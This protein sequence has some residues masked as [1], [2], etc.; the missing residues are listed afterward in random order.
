MAATPLHKAMEYETNLDGGALFWAPLVIFLCDVYLGNIQTLE[1][2]GDSTKYL[3]MVM[4][5]V[6]NNHHEK[7]Q[8]RFDPQI[9]QKP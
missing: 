2:I 8:F 3:P 9:N 7:G 4:A 5:V 6:I 1:G